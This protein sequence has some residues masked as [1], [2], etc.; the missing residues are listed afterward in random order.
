[1]EKPTRQRRGR[2]RQGRRRESER[3]RRGDRDGEK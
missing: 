3:D 2:K 1:M